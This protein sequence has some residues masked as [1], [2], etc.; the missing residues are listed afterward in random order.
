M[1]DDPPVVESIP[2]IS[3]SSVQNIEGWLS[4]RNCELRSALE[5]GDSATV[6]R[7]GALV[8]QRSAQLASLVQGMQLVGDGEARSS[9]MAALI[10]QADAK[11]R[12]VEVVTSCARW[13]RP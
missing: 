3:V 8:A 4:N 12:C 9:L 11:R 7:V 10:D 2:S 5:F 13:F 6:A 1:A